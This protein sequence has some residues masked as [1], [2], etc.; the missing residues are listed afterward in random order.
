MSQLS[1][2]NPSPYRKTQLRIIKMHQDVWNTAGW[3]NLA[4]SVTG[5]RATFQAAPRNF[6]TFDF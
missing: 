1:I 3:Q 6:D 5:S 4:N 2:T